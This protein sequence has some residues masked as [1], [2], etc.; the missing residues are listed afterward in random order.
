MRNMDKD[1]NSSPR[2]FFGQPIDVTVEGDVHRP[3][4]FVLE[5]ET[6]EVKEIL[7][8]WQDSGFGKGP[9]KRQHRWWQRHHRNYYRIKTSNDEVFEI[10]H[11]RGAKTEHA[12]YRKWFVTRQF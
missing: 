7:L 11:D 9:Q 3:A 1:W 10:Y 4:S 6:Y 8:Y 5:G 2:R 12:Q